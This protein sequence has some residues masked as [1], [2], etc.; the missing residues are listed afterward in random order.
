M[1]HKSERRTTTTKTVRETEAEAVAYVVGKAVGLD[2]GH[3]SA[4][5]IQIYHGN[6]SLLTESLEVIQQTSAVILAALEPPI[7][8]DTSEQTEALAV[9]S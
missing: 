9:A 3:A 4:S 6:A 2:N 5:Y 7:V 1:L 8:A